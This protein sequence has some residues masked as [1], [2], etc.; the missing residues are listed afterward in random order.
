MILVFILLGLIAL[1][2]CAI[3]LSTIRIEIQDLRLSNIEVKKET[4]YKIKISLYLFN[5]IK[6]L[7]VSLNESKVKELISKIPKIDL[8]KVEQDFNIE[9]IKEL[10]K[11]YVK[12]SKFNL[13]AIIGL[14]SPIITAFLIS[15][16][17]SIIAIIL[18]RVIYK[19]DNKKYKYLIEPIYQNKN[20]YKIKLNCI[21]ELKVVHIINVIYI[22]IK[23]G[24]SDKNERTTSNRKPYAY[25]HE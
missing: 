4:K 21:I 2:I 24:K 7:G 15:F 6:W 20:L 16:V 19:W 23:K 10:K 11:L 22:F 25:S 13:Q 17:S 18:P 5:Y 3:V 14:E 12:I 9:N 8:I 1:V